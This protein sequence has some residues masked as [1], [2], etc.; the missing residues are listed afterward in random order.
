M[1][2]FGKRFFN[3]SAAFCST[4]PCR[5]FNNSISNFQERDDGETSFDSKA[6][7]MRV[8]ST[9]TSIIH[10]FN[11]SSPYF[12]HELVDNKEYNSFNKLDTI[13]WLTSNSN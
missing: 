8:S 1:K 13:V 3:T 5:G 2:I 9:K 12:P 7:A 11:S 6:D 10:V 4:D